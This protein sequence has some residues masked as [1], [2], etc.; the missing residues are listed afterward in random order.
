MHR[1]ACLA[2]LAGAG[3]AACA[4]LPNTN[5]LSRDQRAALAFSGIEVTTSGAAFE[6]TLAADYSSALA[7]DLEG[8]LQREFADRLNPDGARLIVEI[9]RFNLAGSAATAFG[10][11][12]SRLL[13]T[14]RVVSP[15]GLL[16]ATYPIQVLAGEAA[17]SRTGAILGAA[18]NRAGGYYRDL[19]T[20][21]ARDTREQILGGDLPGQRL[22]RN[23][24]SG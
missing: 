12:Q 6:S 24:T 8:V 16:L 22:I 18:T 23:I 9:S 10:R 4:P 15:G 14:V 7:P 3:L 21:F 20:G 5:P 1:R 19:V 2:L 17:E 11:D 13:G